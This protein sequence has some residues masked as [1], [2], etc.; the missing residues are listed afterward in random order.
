VPLPLP[1]PPKRAGNKVE[2]T[3]TSSDKSAM[4]SSSLIVPLVVAFGC[5]IAFSGAFVLFPSTVVSHGTILY[6]L[7]NDNDNDNDDDAIDMSILNN[8]MMGAGI[9]DKSILEREIELISRLDPD[10]AK[11]NAE[12]SDLQNQELVVS[13]LWTIWYG[14]KGPSNEQRLRNIEES[15]GD[16]SQ[17]ENAEQ[18]YM[19]LINEHCK[20]DGESKLNL[21]KWVEPANRLATLL[22][23]MGRL[24]ES[25]AWCEAILEAKPWHIGALS[26]IVMVCVKLNDEESAKKYISMGLP[27]L[28]A[29]MRSARKAWVERNVE[30]ATEQLLQLQSSNA[31]Y[32]K[33]NKALQSSRE[34]VS[35]DDNSSSWQ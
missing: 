20:S 27:N 26:G 31:I 34:I 21:S 19:E 23:L 18:Q 17:W 16:P 15:L 22:Y 32:E 4:Y 29:E 24:Q 33:I 2:K 7:L 6:G 9:R 3:T 30:V 5:S 14:E 35:I 1:A 8:K 10:H 12:Y 13:Q 28:S 11:N 25:K